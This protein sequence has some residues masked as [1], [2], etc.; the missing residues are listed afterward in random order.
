MI[1]RNE[2]ITKQRELQNIEIIQ[3]GK[4]LFSG[5]KLQTFEITKQPKKLKSWKQDF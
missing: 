4:I 3:N 1:T 2:K 5:D